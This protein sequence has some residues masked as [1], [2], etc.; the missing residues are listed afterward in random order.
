MR[1]LD[2]SGSPVGAPEPWP[3]SLSP[4]AE[5]LLNYRF[6]MLV[7]WRGELDFGRLKSTLRPGGEELLGRK[8]APTLLTAAQEW[9][10]P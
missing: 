1:S 2:R 5:L 7:A 9:A 4:A 8:E 3:Q 6:A 10:A